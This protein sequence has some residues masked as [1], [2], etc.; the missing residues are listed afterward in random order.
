M[1]R[2]TIEYNSDRE[3]TNKLVAAIME[4]IEQEQAAVSSI[5][6]T[7]DKSIDIPDFMK[8]PETREG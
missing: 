3:I 6:N 2:L 4:V 1:C 7:R 8:N 5:S